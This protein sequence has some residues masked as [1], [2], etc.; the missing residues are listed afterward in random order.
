VAYKS[1]VD[2]HSAL[3]AGEVDFFVADVTFRKRAKILALT[4]AE[5]SPILP[6]I[7]SSKEA[8]LEDFDLGAWWAVWLP[9]GAPEEVVNKLASWIDAFTASEENRQFTA[10][11]GNQ[12]WVGVHG[13]ALR[14]FTIAEIKKWGDA[15]KTAK[16][17]PQ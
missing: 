16:I 2:S 12:P 11:V 7:P 10:N 5:R 14:E 13:Q 15:I 3:A 9:A 8:G 6:E 17:E 1:I 4:V